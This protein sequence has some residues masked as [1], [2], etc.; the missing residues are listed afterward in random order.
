MNKIIIPENQII[1]PKSAEMIP[2]SKEVDYSTFSRVLDDNVVTASYKMYWLIAL[3]DEVSLGNVEIPFKKLVSRMVVNAWYPI[4]AFK[5]SFGSCDNLATVVNYIADT[6]G[7]ENNYEETKLLNFLYNT[8]DKALNKLLKDLTLNVPYRFLSPFLNEKV[9]HKKKPVKELEELSRVEDNC[10]YG[11]FKDHNNENFIRIKDGW[12]DYLKYNYR[13]IKGWAYY[14]LVCFLQ[15][16]NPNVPAIPFKLEPPRKRELTKATNLWKDV[17]STSKIV[18]IYTGKCFTEENYDLHGGLS[19]DHFIPWSFVLHDQIWN[20][21]PTFKNINSKKSDDLL[22]YDKYIADFCDLQYEAFAH[23]CKKKD[24][25]IVAEYTDA[26]RIESIYEFY[27]N[28]TKEMFSQELKKC[29]SPLYQI[30]ANQGF[31]VREKLI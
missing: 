4:R 2:Y 11:I 25:D 14:K 22:I 3:L 13:I 26:L 27:K 29:I 18:D 23:A 9:L 16:R 31:K 19:I 1:L 20:L 30:A 8:E 21:V 10:I 24:K 12:I 15:K 28:G 5:L 7:F 6:Y 17:I